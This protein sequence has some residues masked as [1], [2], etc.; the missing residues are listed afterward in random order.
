MP[1]RETPSL[2]SW[3]GQAAAIVQEL[4]AVT[5]PEAWD[6]L[7]DLRRHL[8]GSVDC[9]EILDAFLACRERLEADHYLPFY[10]MRRLLAASLRLEFGIEGAGGKVRPLRELLQGGHRS[11]AEIRRAVRRDAFEHML[12]AP[13]SV[14]LVEL[15]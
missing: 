14:R 3:R 11:M 6:L 1:N 8:L 12:E 2:P 9:G 10:R 5:S 13:E 4:F 15:A 7:L